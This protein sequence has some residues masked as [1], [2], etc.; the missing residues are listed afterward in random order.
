M[1]RYV[2]FV[3][4]NDGFVGIV[5][6]HLIVES[7][8]DLVKLILFFHFSVFVLSFLY[9]PF[10]G[11]TQQSAQQDFTRLKLAPSPAVSA[12]DAHKDDIPRPLV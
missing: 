9:T 12:L 5:R 6:N 10:V 11:N 4:V 3:F 8:K 1:Q 2:G 7:W